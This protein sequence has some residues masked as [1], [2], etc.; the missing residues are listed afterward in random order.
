MKPLV[1]IFCI[2][3]N[4]KN[5]IAQAL[6]SFVMQKTNFPFEIVVGDDASTDGTAEIIAQY[7]AQY[8]ELIKPIYHAQN[9]GGHQ[10][11]IDVAN[12]CSGKYVALCEG[13]DYWTDEYKLQKQVDFLESHPECTICFHPVNVHYETK[14]KC[15]EFFPT[16]RMR[17]NKTTLELVDLL[18]RNFIQTNSVMYRWRF[19]KK[20]TF[21]SLWPIKDFLPGDWY[22]HLLHA[23]IGKIGFLPDIMSVY[24]KHTN[25]IWNDAMVSDE[26]FLRC[27]GKH[28]RFW[29][30]VQEHFNYSTSNEIQDMLKK[31]IFAMLRKHNFRKIE[32]LS[33][34]FPNDYQLVTDSLNTSVVSFIQEK[35]KRKLKKYKTL[36]VVSIVTNLLFTFLILIKIFET[37]GNL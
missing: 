32:S 20:E 24:R 12:K 31:T 18:K 10:N 35:I 6:D 21:E 27:G 1:S 30:Y 4:Q 22:L 28:L 26:W 8:S 37:G 3:Y 11:S 29:Q 9:T 14:E 13:D 16:P 5:F 15:D 34:E 36:L 19:N 33:E 2:T 7:A 17:F 25:G 23:E